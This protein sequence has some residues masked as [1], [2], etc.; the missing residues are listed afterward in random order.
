MITLNIPI[1]RG[2]E[3]IDWANAVSEQTAKYGVSAPSSGWDDWACALINSLPI[4]QL[5]QPSGFSKWDDWA[6]QFYGCVR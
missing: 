1:P 6:E 3:F 5:P 2:M 4:G